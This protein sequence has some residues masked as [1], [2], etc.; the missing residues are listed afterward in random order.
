[1]FNI[2]NIGYKIYHDFNNNE[3][4]CLTTD[5]ASLWIK[6]VKKYLKN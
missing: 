6:G 1:M 4:C 3:M 5:I 2:F